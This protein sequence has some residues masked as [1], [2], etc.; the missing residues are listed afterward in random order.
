MLKGVKKIIVITEQPETTKKIPLKINT[1]L[2]VTSNIRCI[3]FF[4]N[5]L[6]NLCASSIF[7]K[8]VE[9]K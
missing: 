3:S 9:N 4:T 5:N 1:L 8:D 2:F 7:V 6:F